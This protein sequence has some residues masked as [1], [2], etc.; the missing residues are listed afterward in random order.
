MPISAVHGLVLQSLNGLEAGNYQPL[1][2]QIQ[3]VVPAGI[4]LAPHAYPF[5]STGKN[6]RATPPRMR[7]TGQR[8]LIHSVGI[9]VVVGQPQATGDADYVFTD[10]IEAIMA[11][12]AAI[13]MPQAALKDPFTGNT[14]RLVAIG[15]QME[16]KIYEPEYAPGGNQ[17]MF[18]YR[19]DVDVTVEEW[20]NG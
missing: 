11:T 20:I 10:L 7:M 13:P 19:G 8:K 4:S 5:D 1:V 18:V 16:W 17:R 6:F 14:S 3:P 9:R 12:C 15:E 2:V